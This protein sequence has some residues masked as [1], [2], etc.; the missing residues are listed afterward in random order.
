M[1]RNSI[2]KMMGFDQGNALGDEPGSM[3]SQARSLQHFDHNFKGG[4]HT[5]KVSVN[6]YLCIH[7]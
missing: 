2:F 3:N 6:I 5:I 7:I 1:K 4:I